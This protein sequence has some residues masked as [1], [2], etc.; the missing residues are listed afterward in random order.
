MSSSS[1]RRPWTSEEDALLKAMFGK[2]RTASMARRLGRS[3]SAVEKRAWMLGL[4][5]EAFAP[6]T[7][8]EDALLRERYAAMPTQELADMLGKTPQ[9]VTTRACR[10]WHLKKDGR[11]KNG[12]RTWTPEDDALL[13][14]CAGTESAS[15]A[16]DRLGRTVDSVLTRASKLGIRFEGPRRRFEKSWPPEL[17]ALLRA[18]AKAGKS[19]ALLAEDCGKTEPAVLKAIRR[20]GIERAPLKETRPYGRPKGV[21]DR[22][23]RK[24]RVSPM[25][26]LKAALQGK[27]REDA[28]SAPDG[29]SEAR[30]GMPEKKP[31][32]P[33]GWVTMEA[34]AKAAGISVKQA[35]WRAWKRKISCLKWCGR[36][37]VSEA[38]VVMLKQEQNARQPEKIIPAAPLPDERP[39]EASATRSER[40]P[41][42]QPP[43]LGSMS[44][45]D[46][47]RALAR[48]EQLE[49]G[50]A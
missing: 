20:L 31:A 15:A 17:E 13:R 5:G 23:P 35:Q 33:E 34:Y 16:A 43:D 3:Y 22:K 41:S 29:R 47:L 38:E 2:S 1:D 25:D 28:A 8:A 44:R 37:L 12:Q 39:A 36:L 7:E 6:W 19:L 48:G 27:P 45:L 18:G 10:K 42:P 26:A 4:S 9:A 14:E 32:L 46:I 24:P 11:H 21:K 30:K 40:K 50:S 49:A